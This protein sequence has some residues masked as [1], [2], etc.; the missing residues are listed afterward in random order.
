MENKAAFIF[1]CPKME[2]MPQNSLYVPS[3]S[4]ITF[5]SIDED[6][7]VIEMVVSFNST[8]TFFAQELRSI[9]TATCHLE[10]YILSLPRALDWN[11]LKTCF[12]NVVNVMSQKDRFLFIPLYGRNT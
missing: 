1:F 3:I 9:Q 6:K 12:I 11:C 10:T 4:N 7:T 8:F 5:A 2:K